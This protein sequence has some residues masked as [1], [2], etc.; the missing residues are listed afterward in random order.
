LAARFLPAV[1]VSLLRAAEDHRPSDHR[2]QNAGGKYRG[3][4]P[5]DTGLLISIG[6]PGAVSGQIPEYRLLSC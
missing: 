3:T 1:S 6:I 4:T 5:D 2:D